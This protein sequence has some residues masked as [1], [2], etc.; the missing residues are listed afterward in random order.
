MLY[1]IYIRNIR[2]SIPAWSIKY[3]QSFIY[4]KFRVLPY[5]QHI[6]NRR[7]IEE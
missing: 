4:S 1:M 3:T 7:I 2:V 6:N 5:S